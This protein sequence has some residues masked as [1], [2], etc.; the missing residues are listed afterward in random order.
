MPQIN[1]I[2]S[3]TEQA[4]VRWA[5]A[6]G[7][8][9]TKLN[10][11][12][13]RGW[14]DRVFWLAGGRPLLMEFKRLGSKPRKLQQA[15]HERLKRLGYD[16]HCIDRAEDGINILRNAIGKIAFNQAASVG[17]TA[18]E[19]ACAAA[20]KLE[21]LDGYNVGRSGRARAVGAKGAS[22]TRVAVSAG[23]GVRRVVR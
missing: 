8:E 18:A 1:Q 17:A 19:A 22:Q 15:V 16:T 6:R 2:E 10:L 3:V 21:Q 23:A 11:M 4:V 13:Q 12:G 5:V 14:P 20:Y 7:I 9:Q